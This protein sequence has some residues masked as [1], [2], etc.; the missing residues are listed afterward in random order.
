M[1]AWTNL[2]RTSSLGRVETAMASIGVD[3]VLMCGGT[4]GGTWFGD[5]WLGADFFSTGEVL[6]PLIIK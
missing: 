6:L 2:T 1:G 4:N 5:T 3:Q